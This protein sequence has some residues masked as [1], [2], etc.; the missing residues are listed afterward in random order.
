[1]EQPPSA[2]YP[3]LYPLSLIM[4]TAV[5]VRQGLYATGILQQRY[6]PR[7]VISIGNLSLG[8]EGK[9]PLVI[10]V[11]RLL[12]ELGVTPALLSRGYGRVHPKRT[13]ILAP[14]NEIPSAWKV[15][16]DEPALVRRASP[17]I[18]TG[19]S[20][21]R[22]E[23]ACEIL[24]HDPRVVFVLDDGFQHR[25]LH[26]D[27]DIVVIDCLRPLQSNR[28]IPLGTLR[29]PLGSLRRADA[30]V[31]NIGPPGHHTS[32]IEGLVRKVHGGARVFHCRQEIDAAI[33]LQDWQRNDPKPDTGSLITSAFLVA[34][35]GNP[36]RFQRDV[37]AFGV[38]VKG[39]RFLRDHFQ[40]SVRE[41]HSC[42]DE[43][44]ALGAQAILTTGKDVIKLSYPPNFPVYVASQ[45]IR[46]DED[47][48]FRS[49]TEKALGTP[50]EGH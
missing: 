47:R 34:A 30:V 33:R 21:Q 28:L 37:E 26:R 32:S 40:L 48:E 14:G 5:G 31:L 41:W 8:G 25:S 4:R 12:R 1:M 43:A 18:W 13:R 27:L 17:D 45:R 24:K 10:Y 22:Y 36:K 19:I 44:R 2:L 50:V 11:T 49:L 20:Q 46:I 3:L 16:G 7:P 9:T 42:A 15:L 39:A 6:L 38:R 23:A 35:I 29:E